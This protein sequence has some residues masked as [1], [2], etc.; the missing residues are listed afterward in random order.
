[1]LELTRMKQIVLTQGD[2]FGD[3]EVEP[4]PPPVLTPP[5]AEP[6]ADPSGLPAAIP[7][8]GDDAPQPA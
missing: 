1:M 2:E 4:A 3:I 8:A 6:P 7:L 5:P